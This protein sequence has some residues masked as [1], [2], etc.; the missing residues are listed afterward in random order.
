MVNVPP[1]PGHLADEALAGYIDGTLSASSRSSVEAHL[2]DCATCRAEFVAASRVADTAPAP[3]RR[4]LPLAALA[5]VAAA[6]VIVVARRPGAPAEDRI[7]SSVDAS[8]G[9]SALTVVSP[10]RADPVT[11]SQLRFVW[12]PGATV[13]EYTVTV[14]DADGHVRWA[15]RTSDTSVTLPDSVVIVPGA[16]LHWYVDGLRADGRSVGT[17][18]QQLTVR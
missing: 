5:A 11:P 1:P 6:I 18:R 4:R 3:V 14:Q 13:M 9:A 10:R 2:A 15:T 17:G 7:R 16:V 12:R 8:A